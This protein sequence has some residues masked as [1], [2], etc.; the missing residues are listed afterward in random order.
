[1]NDHIQ[2]FINLTDGEQLL[3]FWKTIPAELEEPFMAEVEQA[4][5]RAEQEGQ[6]ELAGALSQKLDGFRRLREKNQA[7]ASLLGY[8]NAPSLADARQQI[9][10]HP[11]LLTETIEPL[12]DDLMR[13]YAGDDKA[14]AI[15]Q[16]RRGFLHTCRDRGVEAVFASFE[17]PKPGLPEFQSAVAEYESLAKA[18]QQAESDF[19]SWRIAVEAG[20]QLLSDDWRHLPDIDWA[21]LR[22]SLATAYNEL[23]YARDQAGDPKAALAAFDRAAQ[24]EPTEAAWQRNRATMLIDLGRLDEAAQAIETSRALDPDAVELVDLQA[25][26]DEKRN[27]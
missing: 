19:V 21:V 12:F 22:A 7:V 13:Q 10:G 1:M 15:L 27:A 14:L 20:E 23:G 5:Q 4:I 24:L 2:E 6:T 25:E 18:A 3:A 26:W 8:L 9:E 17:R 16:A 11:V